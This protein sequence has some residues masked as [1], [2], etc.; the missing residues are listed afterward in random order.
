MISL[1]GVDEQ[2]LDVPI[3][4]VCGGRPSFWILYPTIERTGR[5]GWYWLHSDEYLETDPTS[6]KLVSMSF[7]GSSTTLDEIVLVVCRPKRDKWHK[8]TSE[9]PTFQEVLQLAR[10]LER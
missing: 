6:D 7:E 8:F 5:Y 10:R 1:S 9:H 4:P 2:I 3:C